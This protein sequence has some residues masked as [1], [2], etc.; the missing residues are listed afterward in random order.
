MEAA[1]KR[2]IKPGLQYNN[3]F[4]V[5]DN[6]DSTLAVDGN[7]EDTVEFMGSYI[8]KYLGDTAK[9]APKLKGK[10]LEQTLKNVWSFVYN[11]IQYKLDT[12]GQEQLRRPAR[13]WMERKT[14]VDC[15]CYTIFISTILVNLGIDPIIRIVQ[16]PPATSWHHVY[17]IVKSK[18]KTYVLDA[19]LD[20]FNYEK[21]FERKKDFTMNNLGIPIKGLHG[22]FDNTNDISD[23]ELLGFGTLSGDPETDLYNHLVKTREIVQNNP[24]AIAL[25]DN[26]G[27][28]IAELDM[29]IE[30]WN[31]PQRQEVLNKLAQAE[32]KLDASHPLSGEELPEDVDQE[33]I[34]E[35]TDLINNPDET[36]FDSVIDGSGLGAIL[37]AKF[38]KLDQKKNRL[39]QRMPHIRNAGK[40]TRLN[41]RIN[42]I[43]KAKGRIQ[44]LNTL[45]SGSKNKRVARNGVRSGS[46]GEK[47]INEDFGM[48]LKNLVKV[49]LSQLSNLTL[50]P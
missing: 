7:V 41:H 21:P 29:A 3:L 30:A 28:F 48:E 33:D 15:D 11:H 2:N 39:V 45:N 13:S 14:G 22:I 25:Y 8:Q 19:V 50:F 17:P 44:L 47:I 24:D 43:K 23:S 4:P 49:L 31:T 26:P 16:I 10:N 12:P 5:P 37:A 20:R 18:G 34:A 27:R 36:S 35:I 32:L 46:N 38:R 42:L 40:R 1:F 9:L 6:Q